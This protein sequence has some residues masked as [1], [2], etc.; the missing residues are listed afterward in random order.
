MSHC[1]HCILEFKPTLL[2]I[3]ET[4]LVFFFSLCNISDEE[5]FNWNYSSA[6]LTVLQQVSF[7]EI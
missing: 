7:I 1:F 4:G 5:T 2:S 3:Y 6:Y